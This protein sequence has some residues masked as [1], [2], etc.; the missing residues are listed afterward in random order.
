MTVEHDSR[1]LEA[2]WA[3]FSQPGW[4]LIVA[5]MIDLVHEYEQ[6]ALA[7]CRS[8]KSHGQDRYDVGRLDGL[9]EAMAFLENMREDAR[10]QSQ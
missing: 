1:T 4:D 10:P 2:L 9:K 3:M 5:K 7:S 8:G 6:H